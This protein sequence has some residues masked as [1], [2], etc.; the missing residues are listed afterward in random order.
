[1]E[2]NGF[3]NLMNG[4]LYPLEDLMQACKGVDNSRT[5]FAI[6]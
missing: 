4:T 6:G 3:I 2:N 1:M 5:F